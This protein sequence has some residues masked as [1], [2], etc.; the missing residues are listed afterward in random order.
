MP[1]SCA[2]RRPAR[3]PS[4]RTSP[5]RCAVAHPPRPPH[6]PKFT[7]SPHVT[8]HAGCGE[9]AAASVGRHIRCHAR[10]S[11]SLSDGIRPPPRLTTGAGV[12]RDAAGGGCGCGRARPQSAPRG[13]V[14]RGRVPHRQCGWHGVAG[15]GGWRGGYVWSCQHAQQARSVASTAPSFVGPCSQCVGAPPPFPCRWATGARS[16]ALPTWTPLHIAPLSAWRLLRRPRWR[17]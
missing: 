3:K 6:P 16:G 12:V 15:A 2:A 4:P 13:A 1:L 7:S 11:S 5:F 10:L 8:G 9:R 17:A 14:P